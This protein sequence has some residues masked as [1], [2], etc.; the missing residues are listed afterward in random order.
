MGNSNKNQ[1]LI[2][3]GFVSDK[4]DHVTIIDRAFTWGRT[5]IDRT[6]CQLLIVNL[7]SSLGKVNEGEDDINKAKEHFVYSWTKIEY[8]SALCIPLCIND[9]Q[10]SVKVALEDVPGAQI[11]GVIEQKYYYA[12]GS[13]RYMF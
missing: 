5:R 6:N 3:D 13:A 12:G 1:L 8:S 4:A 11:G 9:F 2:A 7:M 10:Q